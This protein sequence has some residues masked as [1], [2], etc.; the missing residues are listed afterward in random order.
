VPGVGGARGYDG[1]KQVKGRKR[2][3]L[4]DTEGRLLTVSVHAANIMDRDGVKLLLS[5][6]IRSQFPRLQLVC[7]A[8]GYNGKGKGKAWIEQTAGWSA[9]I[10]A[11]RRC[12]RRSGCFDE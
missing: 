5:L 3:V 12:P 7:L 2:H 11:P 8:S 10:V 6:D 4:V 1:G 9:Q